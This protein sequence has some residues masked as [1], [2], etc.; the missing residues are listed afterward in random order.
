MYYTITSEYYAT[1]EGVTRTLMIVG[2]EDK[3]RAL[4][5]FKNQ[6]GHW[7]AIGA[8]VEEGII[9]KNGY[10]RMLTDQAKKYILSIKNK[11]DD[12][13]PNFAYSNMIHVNYS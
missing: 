2:A 3:D 12:C 8:D 11:T 10:E 1:G 5:Q 9:L 13:P 7:Q 6:Y 4:E